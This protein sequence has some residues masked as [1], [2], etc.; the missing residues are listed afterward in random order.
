MA[1]FL[2]TT[3]KYQGIFLLKQEFR[4]EIW[5]LKVQHKQNAQTPEGLQFIN[6]L[7]TV[8]AALAEDFFSRYEQFGLFAL[9]ISTY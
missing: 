4:C 6:K 9:Q 2:G 8:T 1:I 3:D 7:K 5:R